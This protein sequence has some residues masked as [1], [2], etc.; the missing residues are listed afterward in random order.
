MI[1]R[2]SFWLRSIFTH[3]ANRGRRLAAVRRAVGWELRTRVTHRATGADLVIDGTTRLHVATGQLA[4]VWTAYNGL[5]EWEELQLCLGYLRPGDHFVDVGANIG[6]FTCFVGSRQPG[7]RITAIEP[8]P[9]VHEALRRNVALNH[10][11]VTIPDGAVGAEPG[12]ATFEV[13][14]RDVHNRLAPG[15]TA[16]E[17]SGITV[18]VHTLD[19]LVGEQGAA[20]IKI[21]V[22]GAELEVL[23]GA[24]GLMRSPN[25]P[26]LLFESVGH[27]AAFG[28]SDAEVLAFVRAQGYQILLLDG[29]LTPWDLDSSPT[30]DNV[31]ACRDPEVLRTRLREP[32]GA[33]AVAPVPVDITYVRD[34]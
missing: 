29:E 33:A 11:D 2:S 14:P 26:V 17:G 12:T 23:R 20:L 6:V 15:G 13:L 27:S 31:V 3:P 1:E 9:P 7:V 10:L 30:T 22:E 18:T 21:D 34:T 28:H 8:F 19:D 32:G 5:H 4:G 16:D 24:V 25:P